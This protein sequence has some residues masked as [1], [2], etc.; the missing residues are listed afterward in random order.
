ME[1]A[2]RLKSQV[3][4]YAEAAA[5]AARRGY[6]RCADGASWALTKAEEQLPGAKEKLHLAW[7]ESA[8]LAL[9]LWG[10]AVHY[11][12]VF[13]RAAVEVALAIWAEITKTFNTIARQGAKTK[14]LK[15]RN[16]SV[17]VGFARS[18]FLVL[19]A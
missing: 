17:L 18:S 6:A 9:W 15:Y 1:K 19:L 10:R 11:V 7:D 12:L 16:I 5:D 14:S 13:S 3:A 2:S 8:R 4:P